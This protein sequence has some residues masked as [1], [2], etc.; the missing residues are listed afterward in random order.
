MREHLFSPDVERALIG[1]ALI[2]RDVFRIAD[3]S[4]AEFNDIQLADIWRV[5][6]ELAALG[7]Y[8]DYISIME[9]LESR[10]RPVEGGVFAQL[11]A[12]A[13]DYHVAG[14]HARI[15]RDLAE[16]RRALAIVQDATRIIH[17]AN[18]SWKTDLTERAR[19][20]AE[21][22]TP[23][24][25]AAAPKTSWTAAELLSSELQRP[26]F[27]VDGLLPAGLT[28]FGGRPKIGKSWLALQLVQAVGTGG[29]FLGQRVEQGRCLYLALE[30]P[31]WRLAERMKA[32]GWADRAA[33]V[34]FQ[35]VG[36]LHAGGGEVLAGM[37]REGSYRLVVVDTLS[38]ALAGDQN[39]SQAMLAALTPLQEA[40]HAAKAAVLMIDHHNK[41]GAAT[42]GSGGGEGLEPDVI[43]NLAGSISKGGTADT[44]WGMYLNKGKRGATLVVTGRDIEERSI[45]LQQDPV[46]HCWQPAT[47][48][49][50][51]KQQLSRG[52]SEILDAIRGL[53]GEATFTEVT[54][55]VS[56]QRSN[57]YHVLQDLVNLGYLVFSH[58]RYAVVSDEG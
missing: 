16:R 28:M 32:Q 55:A 54:K 26:P 49:G 52:R 12:D 45:E 57:V 3:V 37:I 14:D 10:G 2:D 19:L 23:A 27:L 43:V 53:G 7:G 18:G 39:D 46:T 58:R 6:Q 30:D 5:G 24:P 15:V 36:S 31:P 29:R 11:I 25:A 35:T 48:R 22:V 50:E 51:I 13:G 56:M 42:S 8:F 47:E 44:V 21:R 33:Q 20:L 38:R 1:D 34:D 41:L 4:P 17:G 9:E 40:A